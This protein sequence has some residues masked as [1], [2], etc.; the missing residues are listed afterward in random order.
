MSFKVFVLILPV[1][2]YL[3]LPLQV[4]LKVFIEIFPLHVRLLLL[5]PP[6]GAKSVFTVPAFKA[7]SLNALHLRYT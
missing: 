4:T 6:D 5:P 7:M 2:M 3:Y 1:Y